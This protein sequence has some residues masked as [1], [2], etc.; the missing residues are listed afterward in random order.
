MYAHL[1][2]ITCILNDNSCVWIAKMEMRV[3]SYLYVNPR[4]PSVALLYQQDMS[5]IALILY[6]PL[7]QEVYRL[8]SVT[9]LFLLLKTS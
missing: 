7:Q 1:H 6:P 4:A 2:S 8:C 5:L 3:K 9:L